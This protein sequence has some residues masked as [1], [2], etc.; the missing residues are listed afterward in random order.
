MP[1][2]NHWSLPE[3]IYF[4]LYLILLLFFVLVTMQLFIWSIQRPTA[5]PLTSYILRHCREG[6]AFHFISSLRIIECVKVAFCLTLDLDAVWLERR[7][8]QRTIRLQMH[9]SKLLGCWRLWCS[10]LH[11]RKGR[12]NSPMAYRVRGKKE[13]KKTW[14]IKKEY[15]TNGSQVSCSKGNIYLKFLIYSPSAGKN[16]F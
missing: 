8:A 2:E 9:F 12:R 10:F 4:Y 7:I 3:V 5:I 16:I 14:D 6:T 1:R 11:E 15:T 13:Q